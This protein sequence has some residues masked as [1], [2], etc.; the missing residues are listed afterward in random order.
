MIGPPQ[1][2]AAWPA[3]A[4]MLLLSLP[5][6]PVNSG[7]AQAAQDRGSASGA[8]D[9]TYFDQYHS[10]PRDTVSA[11]AYDGFKQFA[12]NCARCHGDFGVGTSFAPA[13]IVSL[14]Y[15]GRFK[16]GERDTKVVF[17]ATVCAGRPDKG[18]PS[19]CALGLEM[20]KIESIYAYLSGRA[21][22]TIGAGRPAMRR[23][24]GASSKM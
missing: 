6:G 20:Q 3:A 19:W 18:M 23:G 9:P 14:S 4:L 21:A 7:Y 5:L 11:E 15:T 22:G 17:F 2:A 16:T 10:Q 24:S 12:L 8:P 1:R 13:L